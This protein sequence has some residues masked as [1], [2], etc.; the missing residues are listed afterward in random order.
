MPCFMKIIA[1]QLKFVVMYNKICFKLKLT[2][3]KKV[4]YL[5]IEWFS[6]N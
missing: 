4:E 6:P 2:K 5:H 1:L 3:V